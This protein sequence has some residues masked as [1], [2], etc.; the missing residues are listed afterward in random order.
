MAATDPQSLLNTVKCH[1]C[2]G[3]STGDLLEYGLLILIAN[4]IGSG[5]S[6]GLQGVAY[7]VA[8]PANPPDVTKLAIA[9]DP[10]GNLPTMWWNTGTLTWN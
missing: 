5:S 1:A 7:T 2:Y 9:G 6:G 10:T 8:P 4:N 3:A